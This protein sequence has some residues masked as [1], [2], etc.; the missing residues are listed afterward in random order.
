MV[1]KNPKNEPTRRRGWVQGAIQLQD[2]AGRLIFSGSYYD[3]GLSASLAG[4][5]SLTSTAVELV[6][7]ESAF[8]ESDYLGH[9]LSMKVDLKLTN[10]AL[11]G[12]GTGEI[13]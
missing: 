4:D 1:I 3:V 6:H 8:G 2:D 10:G 9:A 12:K 11:I 13:E 7:W 5:A